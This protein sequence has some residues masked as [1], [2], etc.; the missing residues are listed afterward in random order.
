MSH[1]ARTE[2]RPRTNDI[3]V[4]PDDDSPGQY[5]VS[6]L[7]GGPQI[8]ISSR[9]SAVDV[10]SGLAGLHLVDAWGYWNG[11]WERVARH[12]AAD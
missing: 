6:E 8:Q 7:H 9:Y 1:S 12:R 10:A 3:V 5:I 4:V 2:A 11:K